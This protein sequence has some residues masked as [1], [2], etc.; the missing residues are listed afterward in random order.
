MYKIVEEIRLKDL[1]K[2]VN[3][4]IDKGLYP[5]GGVTY[6]GQRF[7]Q[8]IFSLPPLNN[9]VQD[10]QAKGISILEGI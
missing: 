2:S 4:E 6:A 7:Y 3:R 1:E 5:V 10:G 8:A 9:V